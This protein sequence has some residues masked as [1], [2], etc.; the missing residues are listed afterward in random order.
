MIR[1]LV[2]FWFC[3]TAPVQAGCRQALVLGLDVS[4]SVDMRE[5]ELQVRGVA[6]ALRAPEVV[7]AI[8]ANPRNPVDMAV[9]EWSGQDYQRIILPWI[10]LNSTAVI[11]Y[12]AARIER[13]RRRSAPA[14]TALGPAM[15]FGADLL[16]ER[17]DCWRRT[18]DI[19][20]DGTHNTGPHPRG[21]KNAL[22]ARR[23]TI[24]GLVIDPPATDPSGPSDLA[25][26]FTAWVILGPGAFVEPAAGF[27]AYE[28]AMIRKLLRELEGIAL[29]HNAHETDPPVQITRP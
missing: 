9:F 16:A 22:R 23:I 27:E 18:L 7:S 20:G 15:R 19:S 10:T 1:A 12:A 11:N 24:N 14:D 25:Q 6:A 28:N 8:L 21:V 2:L 17:S 29:S 4:G 3:L 26:Y 5:Y 13:T